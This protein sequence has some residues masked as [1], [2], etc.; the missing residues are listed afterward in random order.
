M[1][2]V[3]VANNLSFSFFPF[4]NPVSVHYMDVPASVVIFL[5]LVIHT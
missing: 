2:S 5:M 4:K 1:K 3:R